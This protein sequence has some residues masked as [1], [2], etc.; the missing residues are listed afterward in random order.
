MVRRK[1]KTAVGFLSLYCT[2]SFSL[3]FSLQNMAL[4]SSR[5][6]LTTGL[7]DFDCNLLHKDIIGD[8]DRLTIAAK[9][10]G[11]SYF[12]VP[13]ST[14]EESQSILSLT[15]DE[16]VLIATAGKLNFLKST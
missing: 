13:G 4:I 3:P 8:K 10:V 1:F 7:C 5:S 14:L 15:S 6:Y 16:V 11:I 2:S 9:E 12:V